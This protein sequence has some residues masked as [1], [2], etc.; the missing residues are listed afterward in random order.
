MANPRDPD[1]YARHRLYGRRATWRNVAREVVRLRAGDAA[2]GVRPMSLSEIAQRLGYKDKKS[3]RDVLQLANDW[4]IA[5]A[6]G[7]RVIQRQTEFTWAPD[8]AEFARDPLIAKWVQAM[9][10]RGGGGK[11]I[12][13]ANALLRSFMAICNTTRT[14]PA[15]WVSGQTPEE[16]M[17]FA[18]QTM[19]AFIDLYKEKKAA[20]KYKRDWSLE[21]AD[22]PQI[23]HSYSKAVRNFLLSLGH[24]IP[25]GEKTVLSASVAP[26]HGLYAEVLIE[27]GQYTEAKE[28][29]KTNW[30]LDSD[31]FRWFTFGIEGLPRARALHGTT[32]EI[33]TVATENGIV[34]KMTSYETKTET[35]WPKYIHGTDTKKSIDMVAKRGGYLIE[36]RSYERAKR[37]VYKNIRDVYRH[38]GLHT[39]HLANRNDPDSGYFMKH[40]GHALRHCGAQRWLRLTNWNIEFVAKMGWKTPTELTQSY[41]QMPAA[42]QFKLLGGLNFG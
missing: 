14:A 3:V 15:Q 34:Y 10:R 1:S 6:M 17:E 13:T 28:Y 9:G 39:K 29:I 32:T 11:S 25:R 38:L 40:P 30:G 37:I 42:T 8:V 23:T 2:A 36:E 18:R 41:G 12:K 26:F 20:I 35:S 4:G 22:I 27:E 31:T 21:K 16:V 19:S 5:P 7:G 33:E 24:S